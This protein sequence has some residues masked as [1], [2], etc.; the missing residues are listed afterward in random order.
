[1]KRIVNKRELRRLAAKGQ[2]EAVRKEL[3]GHRFYGKDIRHPE[4]FSSDMSEF[5][6]HIGLRTTQVRQSKNFVFFVG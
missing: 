5:G 3:W 6:F 1:M 2:L 4:W